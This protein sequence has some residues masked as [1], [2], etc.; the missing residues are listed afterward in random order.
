MCCF[1]NTNET[2]KHLFFDCHYAKQI[3]RIVYLATGLSRCKSVSH[4]LENWFQILGDKMKKIIMAGVPHYVG[5]F[6]DV[7]TT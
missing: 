7:G 4:M 5:P 6:G 2:I 3:W 1:C